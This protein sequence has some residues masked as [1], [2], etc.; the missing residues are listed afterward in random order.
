MK[1]FFSFFSPQLQSHLFVLQLVHRPTIRHVLQSL[2][3]RSLVPV[4]LCVAKIKRNFNS[5]QTLTSENKD[6]TVDQASLKVWL[7][8]LHKNRIAWFCCYFVALTWFVLFYIQ[9]NTGFFNV[10]HNV[11]TNNTTGTRSWLQTHS[12]FWFRILFTIE[13]WTWQLAMSCVQ[14]SVCNVDLKWHKIYTDI[15]IVCISHSNYFRSFFVSL[16]FVQ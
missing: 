10:S 6:P 13:L 4:D 2:L 16:R 12:M 14:V 5:S 9:F 1:I 11:Q 3:R 15:K 8:S 7:P